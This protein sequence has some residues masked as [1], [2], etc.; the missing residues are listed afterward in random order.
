[1]SSTS[2]VS[3]QSSKYDDIHQQN[4]SYRRR[5]NCWT[6]IGANICVGI[7]AVSTLLLL[8]A[9]IASLYRL[10]KMKKLQ[11]IQAKKAGKPYSKIPAGFIIGAVQSLFGSSSDSDEINFDPDDS[12]YD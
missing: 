2:V 1:M 6:R 9:L 4:N 5:G 12:I 8:I 10:D 7:L 11:I 3:T